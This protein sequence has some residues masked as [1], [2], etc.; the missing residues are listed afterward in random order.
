MLTG[1]YNRLKMNQLVATELARVQRYGGVFSLVMLDLDHFKQVNDNFGHPVGD[2]VLIKMTQVIKQE[3]RATDALGRW[4]GEEFML[5]CPG[6][7]FEGALRYAEKLRTALSTTVFDV[8]DK[9]YASFGV[10][11]YQPNDTVDMIL[12]R[13]DAA[14]Y[15]AKEHG[16]NRVSGMQ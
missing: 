9:Q 4:G 7:S 11:A 13:V 1:V 16:R 6:T 3:L 10:T 15:H 5:L 2:Q 14:L 12:Q 8:V